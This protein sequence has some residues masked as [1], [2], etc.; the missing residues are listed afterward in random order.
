MPWKGAWGHHS[1]M[2]AETNACVIAAGAMTGTSLD[3]IDAAVVE[4]NENTQPPSARLLAHAAAPLGECAETLRALASGAPCTASEI[5]TARRLLS[6]QTAHVIQSA[7]GARQVAFVAVHGQTVLHAPPDSWQL[8]DA[9]R[10]ATTLQCPVASN[11]RGGD[12]AA[13]GQGAPIT[14]LADRALFAAPHP[15]A[16]I[17]LGGFCN[18]TW[19]PAAE[20]L[21]HVKGCDVCPC[22]LLLNQAARM[23]LGTDHDVNGSVAA[24]GAPDAELV[25]SLRKVLNR[26]T[27][28]G[29]S[30]GSGDEASEWLLAP[31]ANA[32][33]TASLLA[34]MAEAIGSVIGEALT[35][36]PANEAILAGG[37]CYHAPLVSAIERASSMPVRRSTELGIP[38]EAREAACVAILASMDRQGQATT[39]PDVTG[40]GELIAGMEWCAPIDKVRP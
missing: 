29:R 32:A 24:E 22:N 25:A 11:L 13:G 38:V 30:L 1:G 7:L 35:R 4:I 12:L 39:T 8:I 16:I 20:T 28:T 18:I 40:R 9:T 19:I 5:V 14:P 33:S 27:T 31:P 6:D 15:R 23:T 10:I 21:D 26:P 3:G 37:G 17:N 34:S 2:T 36:Y